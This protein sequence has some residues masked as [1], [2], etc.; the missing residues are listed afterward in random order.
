MK[1]PSL[2]SIVIPSYNEEGNIRLIFEEIKKIWEGESHDL[3]IIYVND[4]SSDQ[5]EQYI[6]DLAAEKEEVEF[7][8]FSKN[9]GH[10]A[11]LK[12][13]LDHA[14]GDCVISMDADLQHPPSLIPKM[15][16]YWRNGYDVVY[17]QRKEDQ[18]I[19]LFKKLTSK[20][21][22]QLMRRLSGVPIEEGTA[23][24]RLLDRKVVE[25]IKASSDKYIFIRGLVPWMG[26]RQK[27]IEYQAGERHSGQ[28][29]YTLKKMTSFAVN[30]I[31]S[32]STKPLRLATLLGIIISLLSFLYA[33]YAVFIYFFDER[34]ISGWASLLISVLFIGGI[35]LIILGIIGE[36]IGKIYMQLKDRPMYIIKNTSIKREQGI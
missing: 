18:G 26:F 23:D 3:Q 15:I 21:F 34:A 11:A 28:T 29:K 2:I 4:G 35:Q 19:S 31:T 7:I 16:E 13:G 36:Y 8:S 9:F 6:K 5:T 33:L 20:I 24:F 27:K 12:A 17:T 10:Q 22:Y 14:S 32:F 25:V 30:G 1:A